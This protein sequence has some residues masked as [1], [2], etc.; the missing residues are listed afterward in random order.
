MGCK[1]KVWSLARPTQPTLVL[2]LDHSEAQ[3][4]TKQSAAGADGTPQQAPTA[5]SAAAAAADVNA[6]GSSN[7][8]WLTK[9]DMPDGGGGGQA[10][11]GGLMLPGIVA[12]AIAHAAE[13]VP[14]V[15]QVRSSARVA[16]ADPCGRPPSK[17]CSPVRT[18]SCCRP[19]LACLQQV[20]WV[21]FRQCWVTAADDELIRLWSPAGKKMGEFAYKGGSCRCVR[22]CAC[23]RVCVSERG[24]GGRVPAARAC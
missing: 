19:A 11:G 1:V 17:Q 8:R 3:P 4:D 7:M 10:A 15:T 5:P 2:V 20:R 12:E 23:A 9:S 13:D 16:G 14:E 22:A 6:A 24:G 21:G 18:L